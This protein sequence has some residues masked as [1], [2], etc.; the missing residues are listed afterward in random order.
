MAW[1]LFI[2]IVLLAACVVTPLNIAF[3]KIHMHNH[4]LNQTTFATKEAK[5]EYDTAMALSHLEL[6]VIRMNGVKISEIIMDVFFLIDIMIIF[7]SAYYKDEVDLIEDRATICWEYLT[8]WFTIDLVS[9]LPLDLMFNVGGFSK[10]IR[11]AK[12]GRLLKLVKL[13]KLF[14]VLKLMRD[15]SKILSYI[16]HFTKTSSGYERLTFFCLVFFILCHICA[17][18]WIIVATMTDPKYK[19]TWVAASDASKLSNPDLYVL[20]LYW[21]VTSITTVG[22]GDISGTN[23]IER[24]FCAIVMVIGVIAFSF[25]NGALTSIISASDHD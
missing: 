16:N 13:T 3:D 21:T 7:N 17:C 2:T 15:Q 10:A 1:D 6:V 14:R 22:Y 8:G 11:L 4:I 18:L 12:I 23:T 20:S 9:I 25:A 19:G 24:I 5:A